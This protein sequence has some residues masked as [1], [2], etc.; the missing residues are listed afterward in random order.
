VTLHA[1]LCVL[2]L[3]VAGG[4]GKASAADGDAALGALERRYASVVSFT[5]TFTQT[6]R[7]PGIETVESGVVA[8]KRPALM[9]W[10]YRRPETKFFVADG[11]KTYLYSPADRQVMVARFSE[12]ELRS[13]PLEFLLGGASLVRGFRATAERELK[14]KLEGTSMLHLEP[15]APQSEYDSIVLEFDSRTFDIRR[16]VVREATGGSSDFLFSEIATNVRLDDRQ[17]QFRMP[18]GVEVIELD[19]GRE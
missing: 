15:R 13:T 6:Y 7:A 18:K 5:A 8:M 12:R 11:K 1:A 4:L 9:R 3:L 2:A 19:E 16:L 10:E 14:P 17:F